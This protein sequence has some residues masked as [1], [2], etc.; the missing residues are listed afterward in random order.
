MSKKLLVVEINA[1]DHRDHGSKDIRGVKT[2]TQTHFKNSELHTFACKA[3][4]CHCRDAFKI[5]GM[6]AKLMCGKQLLDERPQARENLRERLVTYF[7]AVDAYP[8][9]DFFQMRRGV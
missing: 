2:P 9:V 3:F 8:L 1:R 6:R 7:F 5:S 4:K